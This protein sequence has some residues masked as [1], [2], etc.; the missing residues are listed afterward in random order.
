MALKSCSVMRMLGEIVLAG[1]KPV[2]MD[3][4]APVG[5]WLSFSFFGLIGFICEGG[6]VRA[7]SFA[8]T[9]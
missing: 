7:A 3:D 4:S 8:G 2:R 5:L 1:G 9:H 6:G